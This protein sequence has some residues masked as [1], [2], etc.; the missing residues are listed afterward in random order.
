M[1]RLLDSHRRPA[2][3]VSNP[4]NLIN[5]NEITQIENHGQ[6]IVELYLEKVEKLTDR[7]RAA[8]IQTIELLNRPILVSSL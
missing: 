7:E 8:L 4:F 1:G 6:R 3:R 2:F 5:M